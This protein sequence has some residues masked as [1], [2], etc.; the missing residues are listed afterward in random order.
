M[1]TFY[2]NI[3]KRDKKNGLYKKQQGGLGGGF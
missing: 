2:N 3:R 1:M